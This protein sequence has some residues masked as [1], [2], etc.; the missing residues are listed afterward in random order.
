MNSVS[1]SAHAR[2]L[3][4]DAI[5][6]DNVWPVDL[7]GDHSFG[8]G[9]DRLDRFA[10]AGVSMLSVTLA[11]DSHDPA[12]ALRLVAWARRY[13]LEN[14]NRYLLV[15]TVLDVVN[16]KRSGR[17][18]VGLHFEGTQCFGRNLDLVE[19]FHK[20]GIRQTILAFNALNCAGGGCAVE[21]DP[22]LSAYGRKLVAQMQRVGMLVD[23]SHTGYRTT[24][25]AMAMATKPMIFSHSNAFALQHSFRN[26]RDEQIRACAATGGL[27]GI[28]GASAYLGDL[29]C[30]TLSLFRHLD[31]IVQLVGAKHAGLG[32]DV[33][34][35]HER[36]SDWMRRHTDDWPLAQDPNWPGFRYA[37][38]E[39]VEELVACM[40]AHGYSDDDVLDILGRNHLR[41]AAQAW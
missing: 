4:H 13:L 25:D 35:D 21:Q 27:V 2:E 7:G 36:L 1:H 32:L 28:S 17:L 14:S 6:W 8:N 37:M 22:G 5:V 12:E 24:M 41:V 15:E 33:V 39:Q 3:M 9:W 10:Q 30:R 34:F 18:A 38:P 19:T 20:L 11:G 26:I 29:E 16:A 40:L 31:H 23:L